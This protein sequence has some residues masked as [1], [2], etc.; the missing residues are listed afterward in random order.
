MKIRYFTVP[1]L[2]TLC[3]LLCGCLAIVYALGS[4]DLKTAF[5]L[6]I[7]AAVFDFLDGMSARLL[8][9]YSLLGKELDS[10]AD[11]V[12][13]G[14]APAAMMYMICMGQN[15]GLL[16]LGAFIIAAFSAL[17][18]ARFN[19][20]D[21]QKDS[22]IGLA[23]PA[24]A[25]FFASAG[26]L[27]SDGVFTA[28]APY[29]IGVC[30]VM[31]CLLISPVKMFSFKFKGL[32]LSDRTNLVRYLFIAVAAV[33]VAVFRMM[34]VPFVILLY[35]IISVCMNFACKASKE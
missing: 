13:F 16:S 5:W 21:D 14:V 30:V 34:A 33:S 4:D 19:I 12:S 35:I 25:I 23:T 10:L 31:S 18:L 6:I 24:N 32:S 2:L 22:F 3:N 7:A 8:K 17:R 26:W 20:D 29:L 15:G 11:M 27:Y 9:S 28:P 1:N